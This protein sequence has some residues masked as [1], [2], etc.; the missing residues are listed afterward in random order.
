MK[1]LCI[2][3][4][5]FIKQTI[6]YTHISFAKHS[7]YCPGNILLPELQREKMNH[8]E[9]EEKTSTKTKKFLANA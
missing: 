5:L 2:E 4:C 9:H 3:N 6:F 7:L 1:T 8:E